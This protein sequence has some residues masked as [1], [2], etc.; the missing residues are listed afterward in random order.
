MQTLVEHGAPEDIL[1]DAKPHV[2]TDNLTKTVKSIRCEIQSLGG[3]IMFDTCLTDIKKSGEG[4][5]LTLSGGQTL[6]TTA[7]FLATGHSA[8]DVYNMLINK[9][10]SV[11]PKDYSVGFRAEHKQSD[12]DLSLYGKA[13]QSKNAHL[14]PKGEYSLSYRKGNRGVYSFCMCPGG[15]V[16]AS[17]SE[18]NTIVT[19]G[20]S[21]YA[22]DGINANSAICISVLKSDYGATPQS[23]M[24]FRTRLE[25]EAFKLGG[26]SYN[27]LFQTCADFLDGNKTKSAGSIIPTYSM[28]AVP[29]D[30]SSLF[31]DSMNSLFREAIRKFGT[32]FDF[33]KCPDAPFTA[34]ETRTSSP[35]RIERGEN[36][37][38]EGYPD[39]YPCG[40][41][42]GYAGGIT[43]AALDGIR[44][45]LKYITT[46]K[47]DI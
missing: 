45:A 5:E 24:D 10:F 35:C 17:A 15:E 37:C 28:G 41:G 4:Y 12:V 8:H 33:F 21:R 38:A 2:G 22:R 14:L 6:Y 31:T 29:S 7:V 9:G 26:N 47:G 43:S 44:C 19:N 16:V 11:V 18:E 36:L 34:V 20:M 46:D 1:F 25:R 32:Q 27:A 23:A 3:N 39:F 13:S 40:E 42:A 30:I